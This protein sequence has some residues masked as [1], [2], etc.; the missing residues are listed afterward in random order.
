MASVC[1]WT[2]K[3]NLCV[4]GVCEVIISNVANVCVWTDKLDPCVRDVYELI[5]SIF[6][7]VES[8]AGK[9][10]FPTVT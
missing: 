1:I 9:E 10:A 4:C 7:N 3:L 5:S 6:A 2:D 8:K